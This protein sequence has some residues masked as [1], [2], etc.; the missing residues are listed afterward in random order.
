MPSVKSRTIKKRKVP[1][2]KISKCHPKQ[3]RTS[4]CLPN[5]IYKELSFGNDP[6]KNAGCEDGADHC[7]LDKS[8]LADDVKK[9]LPT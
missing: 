4:R 5:N 6:Y 8:S 9:N 2:E 7:L 1:L 3:S